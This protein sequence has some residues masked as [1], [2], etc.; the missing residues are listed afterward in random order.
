MIKWGELWGKSLRT[1]AA[2]AVQACF[3]DAGVD[4]I[5]SLVVGCMSGGLFVGQEHLAS[6]VADWIG[7]TP[8]PATR[9]ESACASG[10]L[11]VKTAFLEVASG[12][13]DYA[14][15][16][17][18]EKMTD[19]D[20]AAAT[21]ALC[22]AADAEYEAFHGVTFPALYAMLA[23]AHMHRY[24]TTRAQ[25]SH[26]AV[27]NHAHGSKNPNAQ[28]PQPV[29]VQQVSESVMVADPLR[30][31]DCSP[32]TDGAAAVLLCSLEEAK[33]LTKNP[34]VTIAGVGHATDSIGLCGR[35]DFTT[36]PAVRC[37]F[38][39]A[40]AHSGKRREEIQFA[41]VHDCFTIAELIITEELGF[42]GRGAG[43]KAAEAGE[44]SLGG[45]IPINPSG[46]LKSKGHPVGATG[47]GQVCEVVEQLRGR[48]GD[49]QV[50]GARVGMAQNMGGSG[51]SSIVHILE[52]NS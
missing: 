29:T 22:G 46:G 23:R 30:I 17:G 34:L 31:L 40:L 5:D 20:G 36:L 37:S 8:V 49:R 24:G 9:V 12:V 10:A 44:T 4:R 52:A 33:K 47:V 3:D 51:G 35:K 21:D 38:E 15:A 6:L 11:A 2:E 26:I 28:F 13:S 25:L 7:K 45:R 32:V 18:V 43:G 41:E 39:R 19:V 16:V 14:L 42:V 1:M 48:C 50:K 27:K